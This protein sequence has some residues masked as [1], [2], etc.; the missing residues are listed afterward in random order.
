MRKHAYRGFPDTLVGS[1]RVSS[2]HDRQT[3]DLQRDA[4]LEAG[5][6]RSAPALCRQG[7]R[8]AR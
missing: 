6:D 5:V 3:T 4:L 1:M 2:D 8:G 7:Q